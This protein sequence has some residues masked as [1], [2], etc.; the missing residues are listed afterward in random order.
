MCL[1][2]IASPDKSREGHNP[3]ALLLE[4]WA[5]QAALARQRRRQSTHPE[6]R[7][8]DSTLHARHQD[9]AVAE[10][11]EN[12]SKDEDAEQEFVDYGL[13]HLSPRAFAR[14]R[15]AI[16]RDVRAA[17]PEECHMMPYSGRT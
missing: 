13:T 6:G 12:L 7:R 14:V 16:P 11:D 1:L 4:P 3:G 10:R 5:V 2:G 8:P 15:A 17:G 9:A